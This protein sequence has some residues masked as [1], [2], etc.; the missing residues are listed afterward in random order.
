MPP[1]VPREMKSSESWEE[2]EAI[3]DRVSTAVN[4][5][6]AQALEALRLDHAA[7]CH[8]DQCQLVNALA[9]ALM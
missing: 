4:E 3:S 5:R 9:A 6:V 1:T 8:C 7:T 2:A